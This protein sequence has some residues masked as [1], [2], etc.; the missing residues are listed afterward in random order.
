MIYNKKYF[1]LILFVFLVSATFSQVK[2]GKILFERKTNLLKKLKDENAKK[3]ITD[4]NKIVLESFELLFNDT[5]SMFIP[6]E[7]VQKKGMMSWATSRNAV[8]SDLKHGTKLTVYD[9][10]GDKVQVKD[11]LAKRT[12]KITENKRKI[13]NYEC[14]KAIYNVNDSVRIYAWFS[15][16]IIPSVGPESFRGLPGAILG[17]ASEDGGIVYFAKKVDVTEPDMKPLVPKLNKKVYT[18]LELRKK[19]E[20]EFH[21][22]PMAKKIIDQLFLW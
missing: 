2:S 10:W 20:A 1:A 15:E 3:W 12:W 9:L 19:L 8:Y 11:S 13:C 21:T 17:L 22:N 16:E 7:E 6:V 18:P 5:T 4:D 14:R